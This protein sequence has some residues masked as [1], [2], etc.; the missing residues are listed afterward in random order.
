MRG[1]TIPVAFLAAHCAGS[2]GPAPN[3][4]IATTAA[5]AA[6][7]ATQITCTGPADDLA[8]LGSLCGFTSPAGSQNT[9]RWAWRDPDMAVAL[10]ALSGPGLL[11]FADVPCC[12]DDANEAAQAQ[13]P[14]SSISIPVRSRSTT[15]AERRL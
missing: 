13:L 6:P 12:H 4:A 14:A 2:S 15:G 9:I 3:H 7:T 10:R 5:V 8:R 11:V 1:L